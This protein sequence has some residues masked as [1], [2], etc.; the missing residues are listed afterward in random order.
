MAF[1]AHTLILSLVWVGFPV[2]QSRE[3]VMFFYGGSFMPMED[4]PVHKQ[5]I[6]IEI[7]DQGAG[8]F[9]PWVQM[10]DLNKP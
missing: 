1:L 7:K 10:R 9:A 6:S 8:S 2:P 4:V 3:N 5:N